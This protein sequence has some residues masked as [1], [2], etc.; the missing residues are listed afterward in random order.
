MRDACLHGDL[1]SPPSAELPLL[2]TKPPP[3]P[4]IELEVVWV[5]EKTWEKGR[6]I[7]IYM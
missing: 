7:Y 5:P 6:K 3:P 4:E 2:A 1:L